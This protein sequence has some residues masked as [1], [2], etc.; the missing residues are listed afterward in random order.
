MTT[1][2]PRLAPNQTPPA[3]SADNPDAVATQVLQLFF[4]FRRLLSETAPCA[5]TPCDDCFNM[6]RPKV[7]AYI[8]R[9]QTIQFVI[10]AFPGKSPNRRKVLSSLPDL[11]EFLSLEFLQHLCDQVGNFYAPGAQITICSDGHVFSDVV[12]ISDREVSDY[13]HELEL[14]LDEAGGKSLR[15]Y[16]LADALPGSFSEM[17]RTLEGD[18]GIS[19]CEVRARMNSSP[20]FRALFNGVHRFLFEDQLFLS[21]GDTRSRVRADCKRSAYSLVSRSNAWSQLVAENFPGAI[22]LSIHPQTCHSE[23][24]GIHLLPT[25]ET[26]LTPWHGAVLDDGTS[27]TLVKR[28]MAE[29]MH[30]SL[31][32]RHHRPSHFVARRMTP[33]AAQPCNEG[34]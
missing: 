33:W 8:A 1:G 30:A 14:M 26:W 29:A 34:R 17:R 28:W 10:P 2:H 21:P 16:S 7:V 32:W 18:Y 31:Q 15:L 20:A 3:L 5:T 22:R 25:G 9:R 23:K 4:P 11:G 24:L 13:R 19:H 27:F 6:H 12:G